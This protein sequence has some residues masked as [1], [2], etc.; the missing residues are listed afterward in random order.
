MLCSLT[1]ELLL[2][3]N[4]C[5]TFPNGVTTEATQCI[6]NKYDNYILL[7]LSNFLFHFMQLAS[8]TCALKDNQKMKTAK[9][10]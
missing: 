6:R 1:E 3:P 4:G 2:S 10:V 9:S 5:H 7:P 8:S